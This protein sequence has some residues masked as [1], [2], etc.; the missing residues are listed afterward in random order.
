MVARAGL[1]RPAVPDHPA[2]LP[3]RPVGHPG[4][5]RP[6]LDAVHRRLVAGQVV[7]IGCV[8]LAAWQIAG[9][10]HALAAFG[11]GLFTVCQFVAAHLGDPDRDR[12]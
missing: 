3:C 9:G 2:R 7:G 10:W 4:V 11:I 1:D 12:G 5:A 6:R 8:A